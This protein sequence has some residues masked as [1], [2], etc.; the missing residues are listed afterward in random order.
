MMFR[1]LTKGAAMN[2]KIASPYDQNPARLALI[3][4]DG[5]KKPSHSS[6][7]KAFGAVLCLGMIAAFVWHFLPH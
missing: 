7:S 3:A 4:R 1:L 6:N 5:R 2:Y